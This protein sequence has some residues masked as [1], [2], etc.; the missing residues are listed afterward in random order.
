VVA[1]PHP[2]A[3]V[4]FHALPDSTA[5]ELADVAAAA[6]APAVGGRAGEVSAEVE[7]FPGQPR[8]LMP[9]VG[10]V[11]RLFQ[12]LGRPSPAAG[13]VARVLRGEYP[14]QLVGAVVEEYAGWYPE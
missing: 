8:H 9:L 6:A 5:A 12:V 14:V 11:L 4:T 7:P 3:V 1:G 2:Q 13:C 10:A